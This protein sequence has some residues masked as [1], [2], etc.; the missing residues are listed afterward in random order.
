MSRQSAAYAPVYKLIFQE[1]EEGPTREAATQK[2]ASVHAVV[3]DDENGE[4]G[5]DRDPPVVAAL[6]TTITLI[7]VS[8]WVFCLWEDWD[9][10]T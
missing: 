4:A 2:D 8:A 7:A 5:D 3:V 9:Y 6:V 1:G 10:E